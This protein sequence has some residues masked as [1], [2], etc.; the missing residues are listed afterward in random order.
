MAPCGV[1]IDCKTMVSIE[2]MILLARS[3]QEA[4]EMPHFEKTSFRVRKKIFATLDIKTRQVVLKFSEV[5]Q[6]VFSSID[7]KMI[8]PVKGGWGRKGWTVVELDRVTE[9][10]LTD[11]VTTSYCQVAPKKLAELYKKQ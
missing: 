9:E 11:A 2:K 10:I 3:F 5:D 6:S 8:Y 1:L 7:N 4:E